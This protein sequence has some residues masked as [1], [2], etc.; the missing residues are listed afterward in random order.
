MATSHSLIQK[1]HLIALLFLLFLGVLLRIPNLTESL[2]YDEVYST[3]IWL[4]AG[5]LSWLPWDK[6][7]PFYNLLMFLWIMVLGDSEI[8]VRMQP[9]ICGILSIL[10]TY[11]VVYKYADKKTALLTSFFLCFSPVHIWYSQEARRS[12]TV[13]LFLLITAFAFYKLRVSKNNIIRWYLAYGISRLLAVFTHY[14]SVIFLLV[15]SMLSLPPKDRIRRTILT[16][17]LCIFICITAYVL[18]K[19]ALGYFNLGGGY[20]YLREFTLLDLWLF[21]FNWFTFAMRS[22]ISGLKVPM[23]LRYKRPRF[24]C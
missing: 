22:G 7:P 18:W 9:L 19:Y 10:L 8:S 12:T 11:Y 20:H 1:N 4:E 2:W 23:G 16:L 13:L 24:F 3:K 17:N 21:F 5:R 14:C 6:H 15:F